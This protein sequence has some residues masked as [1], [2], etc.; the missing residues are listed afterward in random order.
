LA[1]RRYHDAIDHYRHALELNP[2]YD[3]A[4]LGMGQAALEGGDPPG[5]VKAFQRALELNPHN[6]LVKLAMA[7]A[8][9]MLNR[10]PDAAN[11]EK[12]VL[13]SHPDDGKANSDYGVTLVRMKQYR[14]GLE[15]LQKA[16]QMG[17]RT[18]ITYNFLGTAQLATGNTDEAVRAYE[19]AIRLDGRYSPPYGNLALLYLRTGQEERAQQYYKKA[20]QSDSV[21]CQELASHFR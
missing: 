10:L 11:L 19:E 7:K 12:E 8:L 13:A 17:Y 2:R 18:A 15:P 16:V 5:A 9:E 14:D 21:L 1:E 20:C 4:A 6:Y 3:L